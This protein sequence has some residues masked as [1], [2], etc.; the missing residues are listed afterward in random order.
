MGSNINGPSLIRV[1]DWILD[2]LGKYYLY[3]AHHRGTF[4]RLAYSDN[5][6]GP[7]AIYTPGVLDL[8]ESY[9]NHHIAS[10]DVRVMEDRQE[11]W[12]YYHG[13]SAADF[14]NQLERVAISEDG[15]HFKA[16]QEILGASYWRTFEWGGFHYALAMPGKFYRSKDGI[17]DFTEGPTL[18]TRDMRHAAIR[19]DGD[20]LRVFYTNAGDCPE[21][22]LLSTIKLTRDWMQ[23][24]HSEPVVVLEPEMDHEGARLPLLPSKRGPVEEPVNQLRDPCVFQEY[25]KTYLLYSVAGEQGIVIAELFEKD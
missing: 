21:R 23:W 10:P 5:L 25:G 15:L 9:F 11:I 19:L 12:M 7:W 14:S 6:K 2:P 18:F 3:F 24:K 16:Q 20:L 8:K 22:I 1:P 17:R 13:C 4:I